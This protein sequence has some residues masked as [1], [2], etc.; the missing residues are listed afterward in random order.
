MAKG[1]AADMPGLIAAKEAARLREVVASQHE[2]LAFILET[3]GDRAA[4][5]GMA[6]DLGKIAMRQAV[7]AVPELEDGKPGG[8]GEVE[9]ILREIAGSLSRLE[10]AIRKPGFEAT[11]EI[12]RA[13]ADRAMVASE[14]HT[15]IMRLSWEQQAGRSLALD[16]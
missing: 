9:R 2:A 16:D 4:E 10:T 11:E 5:L 15:K 6:H 3:L 12:E 8:A 1:Y 14:L 7:A 13:A